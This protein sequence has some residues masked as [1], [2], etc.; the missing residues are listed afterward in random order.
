MINDEAESC[1]YF[2]VSSLSIL[3]HRWIG[4]PS[5]K[6]ETIENVNMQIRIFN[7]LRL[8]RDEG[9]TVEKNA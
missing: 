3:K 1:N 9:K 8:N 7:F 2:K 4:W 6:N 5:L